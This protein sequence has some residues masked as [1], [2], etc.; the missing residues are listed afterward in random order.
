MSWKKVL[1]MPFALLTLVG[2]AHE[3]DRN[4]VA[5]SYPFTHFP[6]PLQAESFVFACRA[7]EGEPG[8][9][10]RA[11]GDVVVL[12]R[13]P[14]AGALFFEWKPREGTGVVATVRYEELSA[15]VAALAKLP[16]MPWKWDPS[17]RDDIDC[18]GRPDARSI[19]VVPLAAAG[20]RT[21]PAAAEIVAWMKLL[22]RQ[23]ANR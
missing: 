16:S 2:C 19:T 8:V 21:F 6:A 20:R 5:A 18:F 12:E 17:L 11:N 15:K 23:R 22:P 1:T 4:C 13:F 14:D 7:H 9:G 3:D 10:I